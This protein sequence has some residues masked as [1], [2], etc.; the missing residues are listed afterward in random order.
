MVQW[1]AIIVIVLAVIEGV[2]YGC[3]RRNG[4]LRR[5]DAPS[6]EPDEVKELTERLMGDIT[7]NNSDIFV[8]VADD[9]SICLEPLAN[10]RSKV[11]PCGHRLHATCL[12]QF[13]AHAISNTDS[14]LCPMCRAALVV[15]SNNGDRTLQV[16][17]H[18]NAVVL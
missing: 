8:G 4:L 6:R 7:D 15:T 16:A 10:R 13:I 1:V 17:V 3:I 5:E 9:C 12:E 14:V 2:V 18:V 11:L